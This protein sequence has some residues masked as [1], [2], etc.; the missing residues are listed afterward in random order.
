M[1]HGTHYQAVS[2]DAFADGKVWGPWL[3]Y[4][5]DGSKEDAAKRVEKEDKAWPYKWF[6]NEA[7][8]SRG[9]VQGKLK[10]SDGRPAAGAAVF[11]GDSNNASIST[12][13]QGQ[14][15]YYT[16]YA[17]KDG[18]FSIKNIRIGTYGL[19]AW[20]NGG[21]IQDVTTSF[22][23]NE[24]SISP[25]KNTNLKDLTWAVPDTRKRIF[26]LGSFDRKT[27]GFG[28]SSPTTPFKH[29]LI[30]KC[31]ANL[32]YTIPASQEKD[33]CFAQS[34]MGT[35][36][37][38]FP[39]PSPTSTAA[40]AKLHVSLAGF[41]QGSSADILLNGA[42]IGNITS[43]ALLNSQDTYRG[44]IRAGEWRMLEFGIQEGGL[45][46]GERNLLEFKVTKSA[47]Y[48]GWMWDS[49]WVDWA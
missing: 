38:S 23:Q 2:R 41:S 10:L 6:N 24:I 9:K 49:I 27:D 42:K 7:Y 32:T 35:W 39:A 48:R 21:P 19:Y 36:S 5:N 47:I 1:I 44:A 29:G 8:Q 15:F 13:D 33:W 28:L 11:L 31:P 43:E 30:T 34:A 46:S 16:T 40:A 18:K 22:I 37:I 4:L 12:L 20:S 26:Q 45:K 14:N 3:W 25:G 17:D